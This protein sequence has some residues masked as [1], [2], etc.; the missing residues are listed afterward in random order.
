MK[1]ILALKIL[2]QNPITVVIEGIRAR[3]QHYY[4]K[5]TISDYNIDKLPTIDLLDIF[6]NLEETIDSYS[7]L[8]GTSLIT[9]LVLLKSLAKKFDNCSY[10]EIGSWR[11]ESIV[12]VHNVTQDCTSLTLSKSEMKS[13]KFSEGFI[14][15]HGFFS[16]H[17]NDLNRI[18]QNSHSYDFNQLGKKFDLIFID[19]DHSYEG[20]LN[21]TR[22]TFQLLKNNSSIMVWH[23]YGFD[24]ESVRQSTLKAILDGI[25]KNKHKHLYHV[26]NTMCAVYIENLNIP[27]TYT[28]FP[29]YP[30]KKFSLKVVAEKI[31]PASNK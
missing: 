25:P 23:D 30:N 5:T 1:N 18:E 13:L 10:L 16:N 11:G 12:N 4:R 8:T 31:N 29:S 20:V 17:L 3:E 28:V 27:T 22:K 2:L 21:D 6:P 9:D 14:K 15:V 24:T 19:G 26:S 7:F